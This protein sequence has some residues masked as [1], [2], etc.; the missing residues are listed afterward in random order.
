MNDRPWLNRV[1]LRVVRVRSLFVMMLRFDEGGPGAMI[2]LY[3]KA[4]RNVKD[5]P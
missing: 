4:V 1:I 2:A 5:R 3:R